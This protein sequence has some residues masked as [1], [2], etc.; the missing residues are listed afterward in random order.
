MMICQGFLGTKPKLLGNKGTDAET[1]GENRT[2]VKKY[3][4]ENTDSTFGEMKE[5]KMNGRDE[6][7]VSGKQQINAQ[8]FQLAGEQI[9]FPWEFVFQLRVLQ[10]S[11]HC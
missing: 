1:F 5:K 7:T 3:L 6:M 9:S 4:F 2:F 8:N 10:L 11:Q